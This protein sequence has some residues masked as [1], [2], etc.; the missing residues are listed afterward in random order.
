MFLLLLD[1]QCLKFTLVLCRLH[2]LHRLQIL[3][4]ILMFSNMHFQLL[5]LLLNR[6]HFP[7]ARLMLI[8]NLYFK[9]ILNF[10]LNHLSHKF[11]FGFHL[12]LSFEQA[13]FFLMHLNLMLHIFNLRS[14]TMNIGILPIIILIHNMIVQLNNFAEE[15][16][17]LPIDSII[18][19]MFGLVGPKCIQF[20]IFLN[21]TAS[22]GLLLDLVVN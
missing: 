8:T 3:V 9:V 16:F 5:L 15:P 4:I 7:L 21:K 20:F 14:L 1:H 10:L 19:S 2:L 18:I 12:M 6:I 13:F 22:F 17:S 11:V